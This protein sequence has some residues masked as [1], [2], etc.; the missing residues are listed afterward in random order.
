MNQ[1]QSERKLPGL[2]GCF[3]YLDNRIVEIEL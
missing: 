2:M 3:R 1:A